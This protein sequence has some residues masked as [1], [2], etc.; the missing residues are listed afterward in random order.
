MAVKSN[1]NNTKGRIKNQ[2]TE[3]EPA[4]KKINFFRK[5]EHLMKNYSIAADHA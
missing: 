2:K 1:F 3:E 4:T 5:E